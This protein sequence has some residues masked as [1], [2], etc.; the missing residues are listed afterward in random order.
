VKEKDI[1]RLIPKSVRGSQAKKYMLAR[2]ADAQR[3]IDE[4]AAVGA[5]LG[6]ALRYAARDIRAALLGKRLYEA[7]LWQEGQLE[8]TKETKSREEMLNEQEEGK[9]APQSMAERLW[10]KRLDEDLEVDEDLEIDGGQKEQE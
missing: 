5:T 6:E 10:G 3:R 9:P 1:D 8:E 2:K 7:E 4:A